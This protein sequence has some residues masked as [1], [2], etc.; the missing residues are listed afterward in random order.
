MT[1]PM[2]LAESQ[3][4]M[5]ENIDRLIIEPRLAAERAD[6]AARLRPMLL[7]I[8]PPVDDEGN[9]AADVAD[10]MIDALG[11]DDAALGESVSPEPGL[12][13]AL[14]DAIALLPPERVRLLRPETLALAATDG[15]PI[16]AG[17]ER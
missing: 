17:D 14:R 13:A 16:D 6:I 9:V 1:E 3:R 12:R 4:L 8:L 11:L 15:K 5:S 10:G 7:S 2:T